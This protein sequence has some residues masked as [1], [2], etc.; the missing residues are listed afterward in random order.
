MPALPKAWS[1]GPWKISRSKRFR[2]P[3]K[4]C[5]TARKRNANYALAPLLPVMTRLPGL[6]PQQ[7]CGDGNQV[8]NDKL[9]RISGTNP[10]HLTL[11][12]KDGRMNDTNWRSRFHGLL[13]RNDDGSR[14]LTKHAEE[15][16]EAS[17]VVLAV[18]AWL[19]AMILL[20]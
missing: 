20:P 10:A 2:R 7:P 8:N 16:L 17:V 15:A 6:K 13:F 12:M 14:K 4:R 9:K 3:R 1:K 11:A 19:A 18:F 5:G